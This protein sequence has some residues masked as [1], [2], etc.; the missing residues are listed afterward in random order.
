LNQQAYLK[1]LKAALSSLTSA[2]ID[3]ILRDYAQHF[4]DALQGGRDEA[5]IARALGDPRKVALE[6]KAVMHAEAFQQQRSLA[7]LGRMVFAVCSLAAINII[8]L[9]FVAT[10]TLL[11]LSIYLMCISCI[12]G[13]VMIAASGLPGE[14]RLVHAMTASQM[15]GADASAPEVMAARAKPGFG[16][17]LPPYAIYY[18]PKDAASSMPVAHGKIDVATSIP[19]TSDSSSQRY[20]LGLVYV[21]AGVVAGSFGNWLSRISWHGLL[22]YL[23]ANVSLLRRVQ[24]ST[25][26]F[27]TEQ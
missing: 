22:R 27:M 1:Q 25:S 20:V 3:D 10:M 2:Q 13:G 6:F 21:L 16:L 19:A 8:L 5:E 15:P 7:N 24:S 23:R 14:H 12:T 18:E 9:P 26:Q 11:L 4:A 17:Y